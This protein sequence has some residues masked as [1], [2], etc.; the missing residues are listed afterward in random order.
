MK[1]FVFRNFSAL[2][3][4]LFILLASN[5][6]SAVTGGTLKDRC[7]HIGITSNDRALPEGDVGNAH[8]YDT[9]LCVGYIMGTVSAQQLPCGRTESSDVIVQEVW[10]FLEDH[11][12]KL[13]QHVGNLITEALNNSPA[14]V[15][16]KRR[17]SHPPH[18]SKHPAD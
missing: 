14:C 17:S 12:E 5:T 3:M 15:Q 7:K 18:R 2:A 10:L 9:G 1:T 16:N 4:S 13:T 8:D 6:A 11:P